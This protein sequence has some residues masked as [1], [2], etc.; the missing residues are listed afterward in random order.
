MDETQT[1]RCRQI[2]VAED[3]PLP[4]KY[5]N[6]IINADCLRG[7][8]MGLMAE[9]SKRTEQ[10]ITFDDE[11]LKKDNIFLF[12]F[13][14]I[15]KVVTKEEQR[16]IKAL[17]DEAKKMSESGVGNESD[18][19][20]L[21]TLEFVSGWKSEANKI[22]DEGG[23]MYDLLEFTD[24]EFLTETKN[25]V[26]TTGY[27]GEL[28][29]HHLRIFEDNGKYGLKDR[30]GAVIIPADYDKISHSGYMGR[31]W[32]LSI[33]EK[34]GTVNE[35]GERIFPIEY[36]KI[37]V[38]FKGGHFLT[39][40]GKT[41][42][43]DVNGAMTIDFLY[44]ELENPFSSW[45]GAKAKIGD[46][47]G[48]VDGTGTVVIPIEYDYVGL[49]NHGMIQIKKGDKWGLFNSQGQMV[50]P[51]EYERIHVDAPNVYRVK[52]D[53]VY[54]II[55]KDGKVLFPF[56]Y[57]DLGAFDQEGITY[58][59]NEYTLY[60]FINRE[61]HVLIPFAYQEARNYKGN[62]AEVSMG[63]GE[64]GV[65]NKAGWV[66]VPLKY[67]SVYILWEDIVEVRRKDSRRHTYLSGLYD[68]RNG[69]N[70]P[71]K[72]GQ[73]HLK[74]RNNDGILECECR[75]DDDSEPL[76]IKVD[77]KNAIEETTD[78]SEG[79]LIKYLLA[80]FEDDEE[81]YESVKKYPNRVSVLE[82]PCSCGGMTVRMYYRSSPDSWKR[83][84]GRAGWLTIC[85]K[86]KHVY[87]F[88]CTI[89]N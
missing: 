73:I 1:K 32:N 12:G 65:I 75:E 5:V 17:L 82:Q 86:C 85:P 51:F 60:G 70:L 31:G 59:A 20:A 74:G 23:C 42:Y 52:K 34:W 56:K 19:E 2:H 47:W 37:K 69:Y 35:R 83:L 61:D 29:D 26:E 21:R 57:R 78:I 33:G 38:R 79:L 84:A 48:Y 3:E 30:N 55:D 28:E 49:D 9:I 14:R 27:H 7:R 10:P 41:G 88:F 54:G 77:S 18:N 89:M 53:G 22:F 72:Y 62:Y 66:V 16:V 80:C 36:D 25:I 50:L 68:L 44:D 63:L 87:N 11:I 8:T 67:E 71:C 13:L 4:I 64:K 39:K 24:P 6:K 58:A 15:A 76:V 43:C 40:N 45:E 46:K 81:L